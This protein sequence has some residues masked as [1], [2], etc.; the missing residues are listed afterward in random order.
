MKFPTPED[1]FEIGPPE[2]MSTQ[3]AV[4]AGILVILPCIFCYAVV[5]VIIYFII[6]LL[7]FPYNFYRDLKAARKGSD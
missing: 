3:T 1:L 5:W 7:R 2:W 6:A 4:I